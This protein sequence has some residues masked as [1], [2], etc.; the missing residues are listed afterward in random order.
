[1][2]HISLHNIEIKEDF[3]KRK[4]KKNGSFRQESIELQ[5]KEQKMGTRKHLKYAKK[6]YYNTD[7]DPY[8]V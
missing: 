1:M 6:M 8:N 7:L 5:I 3:R 2:Q 4:R